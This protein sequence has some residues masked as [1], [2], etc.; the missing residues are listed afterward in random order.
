MRF[1]LAAQPFGA[2]KIQRMTN[3]RLR[4]LFLSHALPPGVCNRFPAIYSAPHPQQTYMTQALAKL[5]EVSSVGWLPRQIF[6]QL[7]PRDNSVGV[8]HELLLWDLKPEMWHRWRSWHRLRRFYLEKIKNDGMPEVLLVSNILPVFNH[9][10][11]WLRKQPRRPRI[12]LFLADCG[13]LGQHDSF[14]RRLRYHFKPLQML[15]NDAVLLYDACIA[16]GI[17][18]RQYF[19]PRGVPW[20]W[21]P[22]AY[23]FSYAAP[24]Q[25]V[26]CGPIRF[27]Y[28]GGLSK[29]AATLPM[30]RAFLNAGIPGSLHIC[31]FGEKAEALK[32]LA[33]SH[34]NLHFDGLLQSSECMAWA[35]KL[36]VLVNPRL[37]L[38][39]NS[40][41]SKVFQ[42]GIT[43]KAILSTRIGGVD[44]VLREHGIYFDAHNLEKELCQKFCEVA[45]MDRAELQNRGAAIRQLV[46]TEF[47]W[48]A[49]ARRMVDF[50]KG[51]VPAR[52]AG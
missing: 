13:G 47:N 5:A 29:D 30:V 22:S 15:D 31:G 14:S 27:G 35:Q 12:V 50:L 36:D 21:M 34:S 33:A 39:E 41:P 42:Y 10:V 28:F 38:W 49:Q 51:I 52:P 32:Q 23:N 26:A 11:R 2:S 8:E 9:F 24:A 48:D 40:F 1:N 19:E 4:I 6:G 43:G 37:P 7:E 3:D 18:T 16:L 45:T 44:E 20:L 17:A 25:T 46:L